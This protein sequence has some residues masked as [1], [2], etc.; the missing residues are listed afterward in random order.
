VN[1]GQE[2]NLPNQPLIT[3]YTGLGLLQA[4]VIRTK[5]QSAGIPAILKYESV[6]PVIGVTLDGLGE[7]EVQVPAGWVDEAR[8]VIEV[9]PE[10]GW[11]DSGIWAASGSSEAEA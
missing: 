9:L 5:L 11:E 8:A 6:G 10:E 3:V 7:V 4:E 1:G 2:E